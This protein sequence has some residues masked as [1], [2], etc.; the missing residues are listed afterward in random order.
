MAVINSVNYRETCFPKQ[1]LTR[2]PGRPNYESLHQM[3]LELKANAISVHS[4]LGGGNHGHLGLLMTDPQYTLIVNTPYVRPVHPGIFVLAGGETRVQA[5]A[6]QCAHDETLRVFHEVRGV[7]QALIQQI[8]AAVDACYIISMRDR[9]T[10]QFTGNVLQVLQYLQNTYGTISPS[11]LAV[12]QKEVTEMHYD[13]VT[14]VDNIFNKIE[15]L[16]EYG[17]LAHC[18]FTQLQAIAL[19]YNIINKTG[20]F[21]ETVKSWNRLTLVQQNWIGFKQ[22]FRDAHLE[23]QETGE[24][25]LEG[26]GYGQAALVEDIVTRL[27][28]EMNLITSELPPAETT[29]EVPPAATANHSTTDTF[30]QQLITQ[31]QEMMRVIASNANVAGGRGTPRTPRVST[32]P[33]TGQPVLPIPARYNKY[34]WTHGRCNHSSTTCNSK[35]PGHKSESTMD[36]KLSGSTYGCTT[37]GA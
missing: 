27:A 18:P 5:D 4:N 8:V 31:N 22:H 19:A 23:L 11:Q 30:L 29:L 20:K 7:E 10:G 15:D 6:F 24:L 2:C 28:A 32:G 3:Q 25:T 37:A 26:A 35:A 17:E 13:P 21:R 9:N 34:C 1:D 33:R 36:N 14:P 12:F 16:L